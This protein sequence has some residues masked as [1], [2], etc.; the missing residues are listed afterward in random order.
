MKKEKGDTP[1]NQRS[2]P[3]LQLPKNSANQKNQH[4][5]PPK[6]QHTRK[7]NRQKTPTKDSSIKTPMEISHNL[8]RR[9][10]AEEH[11]KKTLPKYTFQT[12]PPKGKNAFNL[13]PQQDQLQQQQLHQEQS[14]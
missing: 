4:H 10:R 6:T 13:Q 2:Y 8:K 1:K 14:Q 7:A 11:S 9:D 3:K 5:H 12:R